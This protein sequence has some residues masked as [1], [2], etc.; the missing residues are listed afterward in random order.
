MILFNQIKAMTTVYGF[1]FTNSF[2]V[3]FFWGIKIKGV[4]DDKVLLVR[5]GKPQG[6]QSNSNRVIS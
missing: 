1:Y 6:F 3:D 4:G 2:I 5:H